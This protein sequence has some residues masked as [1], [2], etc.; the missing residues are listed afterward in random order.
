MSIKAGPALPV[1]GDPWRA[2]LDPLIPV[3]EQRLHDAGAA[4]DPGWVRGE[5]DLN[6]GP[7]WDVAI[8]LHRPAKNSGLAPESLARTVATGFPPSTG[9]ARV[10]A[11][12]AYLNFGVDGAWL[13]DRTL[14]EVVDGGD[15]FGH[16]AV[17]AEAAC[18]EHT[19]A[20][21]TG[22]LHVGR[23]RNSII[24]D[25]LARV[26]RASGHP[27]TTQYYVDD[28]G[29]QAAMITWIWSKPP[30]EWPEEIRGSIPGARWDDPNERADLHFGKPYPAVSAYLKSHPEAATEVAAITESLEV[31][32]APARHREIATATLDAMVASLARI[33][34]R[35]DEFVWESDFLVDGSVPKVLERL[36]Q[37]AHATHEPNGALAIDAATYG[38][39]K[40]SS[41]IIV[42]RGNG[43][44]LYVTR[45]LAYHLSKFAR[46]P[47]VID[48]LGQD[49]L[50]H[51]RTLE[52]LL[53]EMGEPRR[54]EFV[55]YQYLTAP[56]GGGMSTRKGTAV[57]L[58]ALLDDAVGRAR[59][60]VRTRWPESPDD[61]V[62]R[63]ATAVATGAVRYHILRVAPD[64]TV[65]F[66]W[67]DALSFEGRSGPFVQYAYVR[68]TSLL[69]KAEG[70]GGAFPYRG[71]ELA[72]PEEQALIR[73]IARWPRVVAYA[74]RSAHVHAVAGYAHDLAEAFNRFYQG[75]PVL[76][77]G[78]ERSSRLA[79]VAASRTT[80]GS[81][82][83]LL[84][85]PPLDRM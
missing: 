59:T 20:N 70:G 34:V 74:A 45:D 11:V 50:L 18:V 33:G 60:E 80:L 63:I 55:L 40:E 4:T 10:Q 24:G 41:K 52:A 79:L 64:K 25:T 56:S 83:D 42:A 85:V 22:P 32:R 36:G 48:V 84:G 7:E 81:V 78:S 73:T 62:D 29:R 9:I 23:I 49:H 77:A 61:E 82:L 8:A 12:G 39:P 72:Q 28:V 67:E 69:K 6:E 54:P 30:S 53:T 26:L 66:R 51:A 65:A 37:A 38:L 35:F 1:S 43:T 44:S 75:V 16:A 2:V 68:A 14:Q 46:F 47:R 5:L 3:L 21:P 17:Q 31:G 71:A 57:Y 27:V 15:R 13:A 58:D 19:S 76:K